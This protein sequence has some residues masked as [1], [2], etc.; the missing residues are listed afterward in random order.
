MRLDPKVA[1]AIGI[2]TVGMNPKGYTKE[3][4]DLQNSID[5]YDI[6]Y[7]YS[8][9][10]EGEMSLSENV[11]MGVYG[12]D[13]FNWRN[14]SYIKGPE[15]LAEA[16]SGYRKNIYQSAGSDGQY[17]VKVGEENAHAGSFRAVIMRFRDHAGN[18]KIERVNY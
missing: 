12:D 2:S 18:I 17:Q 8:R 14:A 13:E 1:A 16:A 9:G 10:P 5:I 15:W 11:K 6:D 7:R 3:V 4:L